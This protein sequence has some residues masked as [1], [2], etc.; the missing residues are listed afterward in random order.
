MEKKEDKLQ[1]Y[2]KTVFNYPTVTTSNLET[3]KETDHIVKKQK[4]WGSN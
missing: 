4:S 2:Q 3:T 1:E